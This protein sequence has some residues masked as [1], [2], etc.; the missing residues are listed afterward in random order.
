MAE[1]ND[2]AGDEEESKDVDGVANL[3]IQTGRHQLPRCAV[4]EKDCPSC[5][6]ATNV[7]AARALNASFCVLADARRPDLIEAWY[8]TM[9]AVRPVD[10]RLRCKVLTW[11]E[12]A[13][14]VPPRLQAFLDEKYGIAA[15]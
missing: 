5:S 15:V 2:D 9:R 11:Q 7:L 8:G 13:A 14:V 10:L 1:I 12:L 4:I 3:G 6:R